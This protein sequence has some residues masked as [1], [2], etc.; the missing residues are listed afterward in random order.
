M[1]IKVN[2][3]GDNGDDGD[4]IDGNS[5]DLDNTAGDGRSSDGLPGKKTIIKRTIWN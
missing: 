5:N 4:D 3:D 2:D 1:N